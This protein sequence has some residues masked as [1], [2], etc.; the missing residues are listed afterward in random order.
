[1]GEANIIVQPFVVGIEELYYNIT[2]LCIY[3]L[4]SHMSMQNCYE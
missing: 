1:M 4:E 3:L 2:L